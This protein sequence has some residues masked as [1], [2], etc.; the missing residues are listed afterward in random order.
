MT[1]G[2]EQVSGHSAV[3]Y[4]D[5]FDGGDNPANYGFSQKPDR[6]VKSKGMNNRFV[7]L[8]N[9]K[10]NTTYF[11][12]IQDNEGTSRKMS[13]KTIPDNPYERLSIISGG[14][15]RNHRKARQRANLLVSKLR[16]H[17]VMFGGDMTGGDIERQWKAWM[18]DWQKTITSDGQLIPIIVARG[19]HEASNKSLVDLFDVKNQK[20]TYALTFGGNLLR[21]YTL[22]S[23]IAAGGDQ[24]VWLENDL[25]NNQH[26]NWKFAQYHH[27]IRPHNSR[28]SERNAQLKN[29]ATL[30]YKYGL[31]V[32]SESDSHV[33]KTTYP[34]R[35]SRE[36]GSDEGF[37]RDDENGT[38]YIGEGCWGAPLR[39]NDDEKKWTRASGSF[40][41]FKW[42]FV[43]HEGI[44][45][46]TIKVNNAESVGEVSP[47]N[48]FVPPS[49]LDIWNPST[50]SV[51]L[52]G[53]H[54]VFANDFSNENTT[55]TNSNPKPSTK[56]NTSTKESKEKIINKRSTNKSKILKAETQLK[57]SAPSSSVKSIK[58]LEIFKF[59]AKINNEEVVVAWVT[60][61]EYIIPTFEI[62]RS[63]NNGHY[64][65]I[66]RIR[67]SG[68]FSNGETNTYRMTDKLDNIPQ[69]ANLSYR[70]RHIKENGESQVFQAKVALLSKEN[71]QRNWN[72]FAKIITDS[73]Q[74]KFQYNL[75][76]PAMVS[77]KL[78]DE[79]KQQ[80]LKNEFR[81][82]KG[83]NFLQSMDVSRV[84]EGDYLLIIEA[85]R[86]IIQQYKVEKS[87]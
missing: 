44:E 12:I 38:V 86:K 53:K 82:S 46:R 18:D 11:F 84:E 28:K 13:F 76:K 33:A 67:G 16:P 26:V 25:E 69:G 39:K 9:L 78:I 59:Q 41:Q 87:P 21:I 30:F 24:K 70:L 54:K 68:N 10:P 52:I 37:I 15:S 2:W 20:I 65:A 4:Y 34:L 22:N 36:S 73:D 31:D 79:S 23:M 51:I 42:I 66:A 63:I 72:E 80:V 14:D 50:G 40:N 1:I 6:S 77:I 43:D 49:G 29:W 7:R 17:A 85:D 56:I 57:S 60:K 61:N 45:I 64:R 8:K 32:A 58:P 81:N 71:Q 83:G 47:Y 19:N 35:P 62:E 27:A 3:I 55:S 75:L 74:I 5:E 48:I